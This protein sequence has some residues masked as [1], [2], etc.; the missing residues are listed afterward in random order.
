VNWWEGR[1]VVVRRQKRHAALHVQGKGAGGV[2]WGTGA[3]PGRGGEAHAC[4]TRPHVTF[5]GGAK[6]RAKPVVVAEV[7]GREASMSGTRRVGA[8]GFIQGRFVRHRRSTIAA[9]GQPMPVEPEPGS[10]AHTGQRSNG[11]QNR[12]RDNH[13]TARRFGEALTYHASGSKRSSLRCWVHA[14]RRAVIVRCKRKPTCSVLQ[15]FAGIR[16][17]LNQPKNVVKRPFSEVRTVCTG[18]TRTGVTSI[19][20]LGNVGRR[21]GRRHR[22]NHVETVRSGGVGTPSNRG[23]VNVHS[24][25]GT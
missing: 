6:Q 13:V 5:C 16:P 3:P 22:R 19:T 9:G 18:S 2:G 21:W 20:T 14:Q 23:G 7:V 17:P 11:R 15:R 24:Q 10:P 1:S 12:R 25:Y 8:M 4:H